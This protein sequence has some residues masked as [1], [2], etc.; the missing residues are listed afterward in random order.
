M[1]KYKDLYITEIQFI[2]LDAVL[3]KYSY[4]SGNY[5]VISIIYLVD[6]FTINNFRK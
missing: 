6:V 2:I 4:C 1:I 5:S 3:W